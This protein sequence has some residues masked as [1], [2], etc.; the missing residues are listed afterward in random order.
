VGEDEIRIRQSHPH[1]ASPVKGE[2][3]TVLPPPSG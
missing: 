3:F 1:P 2:G